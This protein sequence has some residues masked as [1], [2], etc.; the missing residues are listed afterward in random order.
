M[1]KKCR[2]KEGDL[3]PIQEI[4]R[5]TIVSTEMNPST[6]NLPCLQD[7]VVNQ[8]NSNLSEKIEAEIGKLEKLIEERIGSSNLNSKEIDGSISRL[9]EV[10]KETINYINQSRNIITEKVDNMVNFMHEERS[11]ADNLIQ[12]S[13]EISQLN[14]DNLKEIQSTTN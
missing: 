12:K 14:Q 2:K 13:I 5:E 9:E 1:K 8:L 3:D 7:Q 4:Q 10:Q 11:N 6:Q